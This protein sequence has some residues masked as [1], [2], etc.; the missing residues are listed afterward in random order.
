MYCNNDNGM[1]CGYGGVGLLVLLIFFAMFANNGN[2]GFFG[3]NGSNTAT[4]AAS[5]VQQD[6][7]R[8]QVAGIASNQNWQGQLIGGA[9]QGI[10][11]TR[12]AVAA[13]DA[14]LCQVTNNLTQQVNA[15]STQNQ[16]CCCDLRHQL[17]TNF[18]ATNQNITNAK[19]E[20]LTTLQQNKFEALQAENQN[21]K[22]AL[23]TQQANCAREADTRLLAGKI[24]SLSGCRPAAC[25][26]CP[27][28]QGSFESQL[29]AA[30]TAINATQQQILAK[31]STKTAAA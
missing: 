3:G 6:N 23:A 10:E 28:A 15:L 8:A 5:L 30:L 27:T 13:L 12:D 29:V 18:C 26:C 9:V 14:K 21:L 25:G 31:L 7:T 16:Q 19:N 11:R 17:D 4:E 20:I 22:V 2:G 24:D 1:G